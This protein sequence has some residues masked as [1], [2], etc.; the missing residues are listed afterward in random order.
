MHVNGKQVRSVIADDEDVDTALLSIG[1]WWGSIN[2]VII[3]ASR[4]GPTTNLSVSQSVIWFP[5]SAL[6]RDAPGVTNSV[7]SSLGS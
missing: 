3:Y 1:G 5:Q 2:K 4:A 6:L 7:V